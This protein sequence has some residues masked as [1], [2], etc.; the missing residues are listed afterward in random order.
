MSDKLLLISIDGHVTSSRA[1]YREY[2]EHDY[3]ED[4]D[5][6]AKM[7]EGAPEAF[8]GQAG[9]DAEVN[10]DDDARWEA[11]ESQGVA[12]EVLFPNGIPLASLG[13]GMPDQRPDIE[14]AGRR[15]YN[16]WLAD[17]CA[18]TPERRAG[19][20]LTSADVDEA[21]KD[22]YWAKEHGLRG[23]Q[24]PP[25]HDTF[26][27]EE[28]YD[29]F[30]AACEET[31][32]VAT[33]HGGAGL[34]RNYP[35]GF[36]SIMSIPIESGY[37]ASRCVWHMILGGV[38][39]RFP[40]LQLVVTESSVDWIPGLVR[41]MDFL[42]TKS[43]WLIYAEQLRREKKF[44]RLPSEYWASNCYGG[45]SFLSRG[46]IDLRDDIGIDNLMFGTDF[47]H[48]EATYPHTKQWLQGSFGEAKVPET[49]TRK[50]LGETAARVYSLD[51][52]A[53]RP[54]VDRCGYSPAEILVDDIEVDDDE[55]GLWHLR[56]PVR[57]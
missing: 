23:A 51:P 26:Y 44:S 5:A 55:I 19:I 34:P 29:P 2:V 8:N 56:R 21:T 14:D 11:L 45:G 28:Q 20:V 4:F 12:A 50:I 52:D 22:V 35:P 17:F 40:D 16:R 53:L 13:F 18:R 47:P 57:G 54:H 42:A 3:L 37:H 38:F 39:E 27:F 46:E 32:L 1:G 10:W 6:W 36:A 25:L 9:L 43:D 7:L 48:I 31:G 15:A 49:E 24:L 33:Q 41:Y 30:W